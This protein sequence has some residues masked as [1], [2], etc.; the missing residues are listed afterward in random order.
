MITRGNFKTAFA[1]LRAS[2]WRS[3]LT[4]L[5]IIIG[6][7]SVVTIVSLGEG[8]K[9][10][11]VGQIDKLG[12]DV[13]TVRS[14]KLSSGSQTANLSLLGFFNI[15][16]LTNNDVAIIQK[17]PDAGSVV[18]F[19]FITN[20][21]NSADNTSN[22]VYVIGTNSQMPELLNQKISYG[23]FFT[24]TNKKYAVIGSNVA[25]SLFGQLNPTGKNIS[26]K[27]QDFIVRGVLKPNTG[28]TLSVAQIDFNSSI[29]IPND[30]AKDIAGGGTNILQILVKAKPGSKLNTLIQ[31]VTTGLKTAHGQEDFSVLKQD[32]LLGVVDSVVSRLATFISGIAGIS[33]LVGGIGI[34]DI[35]LVS[36]SERTREIGIRKAV[37]AKNQQILSQFLVEGLVLSVTGGLIGIIA[38]LLINL[39]LKIY[40]RWDPVV[41]WRLL[42]VA[43]GISV[44]IGI[45]FSTAPALKAAKKDP[46]EALRE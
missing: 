34:M 19:N 24:D 42:A 15:S 21:A 3:F 31:E 7:S 17:L 36:V 26:I 6:I 18:P 20:S 4:M 5:G 43:A 39:G 35:M 30:T 11:I 44:L 12:S 29:F 14:G 13:L 23:A 10:Q 16:T 28:G 8:V 40:T 38:S 45:V 37:G 33:L 41:S 32:Q 22:N 2:K 1:S 9:H 27:G 46:I 25:S